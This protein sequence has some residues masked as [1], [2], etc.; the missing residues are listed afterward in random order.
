MND[1]SRWNIVPVPCDDMAP[2]RDPSD[3]PKDDD[4]SRILA[5]HPLVSITTSWDAEADVLTVRIL[6]GSADVV[7]LA[8]VNG[9]TNLIMGSLIGPVP[10]EK[11][12]SLLTPFASKRET[13]GDISVSYTHLTL[14]TKA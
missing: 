14:P 2:I 1:G 4:L 9:P 7:S 3:A 10:P 8:E 6:L 12:S 13:L 11:L 5:L